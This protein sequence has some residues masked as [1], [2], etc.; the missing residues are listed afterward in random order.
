M[1]FFLLLILC[2]LP[3][4]APRHALTVTLS[5]SLASLPL[6][7]VFSRCP[8]RPC[9]PS[10]LLAV[11]ELC[12]RHSGVG[13]DN[14]RTVNA[15][16]EFPVDI[17]LFS[18]LRFSFYFIVSSFCAQILRFSSVLHV[19]VVI[20]RAGSEPL[21]PS[22]SYASDFSFVHFSCVLVTERQTLAINNLRLNVRFQLKA[23]SLRI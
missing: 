15:G 13:N 9:F 16:T 3:S 23:S 10:V 7:A 8:V 20:V 18:A 12:S 17:I 6:L 14:T 22:I 5:R 21:N 4:E 19:T 1:K 2:V 11:S